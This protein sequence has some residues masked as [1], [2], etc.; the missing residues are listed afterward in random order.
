MQKKA[1]IK[2]W[3]DR[4]ATPINTNSQWIVCFDHADDLF[5]YLIMAVKEGDLKAL[6]ECPD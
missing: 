2:E 3:T 4:F 1:F 5:E 6:W